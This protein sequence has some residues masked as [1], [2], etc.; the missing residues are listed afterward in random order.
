MTTVPIPSELP[1]YSVAQ[2]GIYHQ[3]IHDSLSAKRCLASHSNVL[4][5]AQF[6]M[7]R[8]VTNLRID[9]KQPEAQSHSLTPDSGPAHRQPAAR[10]SAGC[11]VALPAR[12]AAPHEYPRLRPLVDLK[13]CALTRRRPGPKFKQ[14]DLSPSCPPLV[15]G[16]LLSMTPAPS[17]SPPSPPPSSK[18]A[19]TL[20]LRVQQAAGREMTPDVAARSGW[21]AGRGPR[22]AGPRRQ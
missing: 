4:S 18:T 6:L 1:L 20:R 5:H 17:P 22:A 7:I 11:C 3:N 9:Q 12:R 10:R 19:A 14:G 15:R 2:E 16:I 21:G 13:F 8:N